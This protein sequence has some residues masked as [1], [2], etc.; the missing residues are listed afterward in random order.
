VDVKRWLELERRDRRRVDVDE[1]MRRMIREH[2]STA[3][4]APRSNALSI[5][6]EARD[7][8]FTLRDAHVAG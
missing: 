8:P 4:R 2:V 3:A 6:G 1:M 5:L 7:V